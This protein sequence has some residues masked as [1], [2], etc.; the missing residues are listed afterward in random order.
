M[1]SFGGERRGKPAITAVWGPNPHVLASHASTGGFGRQL[2]QTRR[3]GVAGRL[4]FDGALIEVLH[5]SQNE[6]GLGSVQFADE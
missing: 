2:L 5:F 3:D 6:F 1:A 4:Q